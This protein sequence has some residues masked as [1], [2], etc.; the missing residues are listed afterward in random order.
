MTVD[1]SVILRALAAEIWAIDRPSLDAA[2]AALDVHA[3]TERLNAL[4]A[5]QRDAERDAERL[6]LLTDAERL[7]VE[8][9]I[10]IEATLRAR[11]AKRHA[12][13]AD[14]SRRSLSPDLVA[15][16]AQIDH[17]VVTSSAYQDAEDVLRLAR[18][19]LN[20]VRRRHDRAL[21][22]RGH[23]VASAARD[24]RIAAQR[25]SRPSTPA[26]RL[27]GLRERLT[28]DVGAAR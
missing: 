6:A 7:E 23:E 12:P 14:G 15:V 17:A 20:R 22:Q 11:E 21:A 5:R 10:A 1:G 3:A 18:S 13:K 19:A 25:A 28:A 16:A 26:S 9:A 2:I 24:A 4:V 8:D 27:A